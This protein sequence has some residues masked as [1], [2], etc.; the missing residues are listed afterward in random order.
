MRS[1]SGS[2]LNS[3]PSLSPPLHAAGAATADGMGAAS[4]S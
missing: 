1:E 4:V 3:I 2:I